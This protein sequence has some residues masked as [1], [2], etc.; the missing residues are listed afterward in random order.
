MLVIFLDSIK[1]KSQGLSLLEI[2][3]V[4]VILLVL[5]AIAFTRVSPLQADSERHAIKDLL[6]RLYS[7][8]AIYT[9]RYA[10]RPQKFQD[11]VSTTSSLAPNK[12][13]SLVGSGTDGNCSISPNGQRITC[14]FKQWKNVRYWFN[15][16]YFYLQSS[17][18]FPSPASS[19]TQS[20]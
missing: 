17:F 15:G 6:P 12:T 13:L 7:A 19:N 4:L 11:F 10:R 3:V 5:G 18:G 2:S 9:S 14:P 20:W 1:N 8:S 16:G